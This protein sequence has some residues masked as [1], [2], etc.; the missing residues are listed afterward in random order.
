MPCGSPRG[1]GGM[2]TIELIP[3]PSGAGYD[4]A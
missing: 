4:P 2:M 3:E 1:M